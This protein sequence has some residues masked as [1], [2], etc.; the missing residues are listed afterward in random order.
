MFKEKMFDLEEQKNKYCQ[1][2]E[3][4]QNEE[5]EYKLIIQEKNLEI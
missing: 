3:K 2:Y 1:L 5:Q 4:A